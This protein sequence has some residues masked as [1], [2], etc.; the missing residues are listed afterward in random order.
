V[1][2]LDEVRDEIAKRLIQE[3][4]LRLARE[5]GAAKLQQ[6]AS[7]PDPNVAW[8]PVRRVSRENLAGL[9][10]RAVAPVFRADAAKLPAYVGVDLPPA[11][12]ALYR[13]SKVVEPPAVDEAKLR[14]NETGLTRQEARETYDAFVQGLRGRAK[15]TVYE[16][17]LQKKAER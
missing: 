8:G 1:R 15:I 6:L 16:A 5:A 14:A 9:D 13:V 7:G 10:R 17:N 4:A 12:Y 3:E 2:P 11:G